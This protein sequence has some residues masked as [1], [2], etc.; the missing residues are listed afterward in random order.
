MGV[1]PD[2]TPQLDLRFAP[3]LSQG[4]VFSSIITT[5]VKP[6]F[7]SF[8]RAQHKEIPRGLNT[9]LLCDPKRLIERWIGD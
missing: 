6:D 4:G 2:R 3:P 7:S 9:V 1:D 5:N 8:Q